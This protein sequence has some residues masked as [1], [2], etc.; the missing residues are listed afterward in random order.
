MPI[1]DN[2]KEFI[3]VTVFGDIQKTYLVVETPV[4]HHPGFAEGG[5]WSSRCIGCE[6]CEAVDGFYCRQCRVGVRP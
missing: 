4:I 3:D 6:C 1:W 5:P 2:D